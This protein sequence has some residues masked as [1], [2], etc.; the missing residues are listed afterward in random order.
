MFAGPNRA[1]LVLASNAGYRTCFRQTI[2]A[3][4]T[5]HRALVS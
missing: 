1:I 3:V 4:R 5:C 2:E